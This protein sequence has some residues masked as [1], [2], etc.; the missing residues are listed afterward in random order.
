MLRNLY[1]NRCSVCAQRVDSIRVLGLYCLLS[2]QLDVQPAH[3]TLLT[4]GLRNDSLSVQV[5]AAQAL[6]DLLLVRGGSFRV[7]WHI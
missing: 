2:S 3:V 6:C 1:L 4:M 5:M 7:Q